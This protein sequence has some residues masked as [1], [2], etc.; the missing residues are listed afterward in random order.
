M[1]E[2]CGSAPFSFDVVSKSH[3][4]TLM[5]DVVLL[6]S[7]LLMAPLGRRPLQDIMSEPFFLPLPPPAV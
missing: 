6:F 2:R 3:K 4:Y 5:S 7:F 1:I